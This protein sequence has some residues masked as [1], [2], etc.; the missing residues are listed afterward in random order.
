MKLLYTVSSGYLN[1]QNNYINSLGG[2]P[3]STPVPNDVFDNLFDELSISEVK[4]SKTQY[5]AIVLQNDSDEIA[6]NVNL[7]FTQK[8]GN[9]CHF[10]IG[11]TVLLGEEDQLRM[12]SIPTVYS[13]PYQTEL[14]DATEESPVTVGDLNPGQ[15][16][17]LWISRIIDK[18]KALSD[19]NNVAE[20]DLS[21]Q[22]R[23]KPI[24][25]ETQES[26]NLNIKW[27]D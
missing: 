4:E 19:Y 27:N 8:E 16:I 3:S 21:T 15:M 25:K 12:E 17:G 5:R 24:S 2:F 10:Q 9:I 1:T 14:Y 20:R 7:W 23:Y 22:S 11:A 18:E 6:K 13:R 26:I